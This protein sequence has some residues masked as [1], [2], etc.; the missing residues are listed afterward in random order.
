MGGIWFSAN[1]AVFM[2]QRW[3]TPQVSCAKKSISAEARFSCALGSFKKYRDLWR[4]Y[5][6]NLTN[7]V[8]R[9]ETQARLIRAFSAR[10]FN[11]RFP[12]ALP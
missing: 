1:G 3:A 12:G 8:R 5:R 9:I 7:A 2:Y 4:K 11:I 6:L 10:F